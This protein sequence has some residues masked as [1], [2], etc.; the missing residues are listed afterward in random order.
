MTVRY[1][2]DGA[3]VFAQVVSIDRCPRR[4]DKY[5]RPVTEI[6]WAEKDFGYFRLTTGFCYGS[7]L[8]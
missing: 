5:G 3:E 4:G 7:E 2:R 8:R 1:L 6:A